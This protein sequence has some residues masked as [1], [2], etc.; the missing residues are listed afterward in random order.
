[1]RVADE[2][3][4]WEPDEQLIPS[5][6]AGSGRKM[7]DL[8]ASDRS[9]VVAGLTLIGLTAEDIADRMGCSLRLVRSI[10]AEDMTRVCGRMQAESQN[11]GDEL[12]LLASTVKSQSATIVELRSELSRVRGKLSRVL[13]A[14]VGVRRCGKCESVMSGYNLYVHNGKEFCRSCHRDRQQRYR[15][16]QGFVEVLPGVVAVRV[17]MQSG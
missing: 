16:S 6:L 10:R 15:D 5:V 3:V 1:M 7:C 14:H 11:F 8:G 9:W 4:R 13:D 12:R 17:T 2:R